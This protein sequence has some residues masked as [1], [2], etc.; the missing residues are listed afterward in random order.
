MTLFW[1]RLGQG[2]RGG[3]TWMCMTLFWVRL[4]QG[5]YGGGTWVCKPLFWIRLGHVR[6]SDSWPNDLLVNLT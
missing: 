5:I 6:A 3:V 4:G 1:V 2:T